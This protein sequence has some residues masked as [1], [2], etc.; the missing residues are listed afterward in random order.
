V[1]IR[2]EGMSIVC[3]RPMSI[4][5]G[6]KPQNVQKCLKCILSSGNKLF[7]RNFAF[8][9]HAYC[10]ISYSFKLDILIQMLFS[11]NIICRRLRKDV[12]TSSLLCLVFGY[13]ACT[14]ILH[15]VARM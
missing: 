7:D 5:F 9:L 4:I 1:T 3:D 11:W 14:M 13:I 8:F 6:P 2:Y 10:K 12:N 15:F